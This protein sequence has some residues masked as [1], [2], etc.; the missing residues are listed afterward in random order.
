[1]SVASDVWV[2]LHTAAV[3]P[4]NLRFFKA[5]S[6]VPKMP[7]HSVDDLMKCMVLGRKLRRHH[8]ARLPQDYGSEVRTIV[9]DTGKIVIAPH[10]TAQGFIEALVAYGTI[11]QR[12]E[13]D[14]AAGGTAALRNLGDGLS[15]LDRVHLSVAAFRNS[16]GIPGSHPQ[17]DEAR[18]FHRPRARG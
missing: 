13:S 12:I 1:M 16:A 5:Q 17:F 8:R 4:G 18:V 10:Y 11:S 2:P 6:N 15:D 14:Y 7:W 9:T 3:G